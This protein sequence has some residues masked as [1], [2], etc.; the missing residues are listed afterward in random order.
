[1]KT[2]VNKIDDIH[3]HLKLWHWW[4]FIIKKDEFSS[5]LCFYTIYDKL[6]SSK[7]DKGNVYDI[8]VRRRNIAHYLDSGKKIT[9]FSSAEIKKAKL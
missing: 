5:E 3:A 6:N 2:L 8:A 4:N 1:M 9:D 7:K